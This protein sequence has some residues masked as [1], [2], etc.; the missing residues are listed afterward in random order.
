MNT[1]EAGIGL[2]GMRERMHALG[3]TMTIRTALGEG[4]AITIDL[5][6]QQ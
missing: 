3:G 4:T 5:P 2:I 6:L 1:V